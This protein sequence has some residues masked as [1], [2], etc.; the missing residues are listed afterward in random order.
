VNGFNDGVLLA[1]NGTQIRE[2]C[3]DVGEDNNPA[4]SIVGRV[5]Y[6]P[7]VSTELGVSVHTGPYNRYKVD[8]FYIDE[9]RNLTILAL[10]WEYNADVIDVIG[11]YAIAD[12][13]VPSSL[14]GLFAEQQH[15]FYAQANYH[16]GKG[17]INLLPLSHFTAVV[18]YDLADFDRQINGD[19][20]QRVSVGL[21]FRPTSDTVFKLDYHHDWQ[22]SR[23]DVVEKGAGI[24]FSVASYF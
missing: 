14:Q 12:I 11:E 22:W 7:T 23:V 6:S 19:A 9:R 16:F 3:G 17:L 18:R 10:D 2:G 5:T 8:Q 20:R 1:G 24:N 21:N 4:P 13:N 15:G